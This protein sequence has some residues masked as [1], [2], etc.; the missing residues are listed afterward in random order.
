MNNNSA[1][2]SNMFTVAPG[3]WGRKDVFVNFYFI[4]DEHD[5]QWV[6]VDSGL[7]WSAPKIKEMAAHLFG[8]DS[9]P[10][11]IILTHGHF[12]HVGSVEKLADEWDVP[13]YAHHL[14]IPYLTGESDYPPADPTVGGGLMATMSFL[15]PKSP[16]NIWRFIKVLPPHGK[17]PVLSG[18]RYIETPGHSPGHISLFRDEDQVLIAGDAFVTTN[19]ESLV[20]VV[21]QSKIVSGPPKYFT[22]DW[23][24]ARA[25]V[26]EL[27]N[28]NP[29]TAATGHGQPMRGRELKEAL[30]EL[31]EN[32]TQKAVPEQGRYVQSPAVTDDNGI[33]S[34]PPATFNKNELAVRAFSVTA[35]LTIAFMWSR[36]KKIKK[37]IEYDNQIEVEYNY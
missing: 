23:F 1:V 13:V 3:V 7:K 24:S 33:V 32:F 34:L 35:I 37:Q 36:H 8:P 9:I 29:K 11:A 21:L 15:Y 12:D 31:N 19:Q 18:W 27:V 20:S 14:E 4:Q 6:L 22:P 16:I 30:S 10:K 2:P 26:N 5:D 17:I 28:L 25:S